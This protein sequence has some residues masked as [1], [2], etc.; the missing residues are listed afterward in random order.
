MLHLTKSFQKYIK[1]LKLPS[2]DHAVFIEGF[3][4]GFVKDSN[5]SLE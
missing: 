5:N 1:M 2:G 3:L 4:D